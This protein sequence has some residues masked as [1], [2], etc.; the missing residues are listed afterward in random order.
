MKIWANQTE[1]PDDFG[2][3]FEGAAAAAVL[4]GGDLHLQKVADV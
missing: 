2:S 1:R 4:D 3:S